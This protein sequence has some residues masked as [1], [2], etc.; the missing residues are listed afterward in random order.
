MQRQVSMETLPHEILFVI[1][2]LLSTNNLSSFM[3][4]NKNFF[5]IISKCN[6]LWQQLSFKHF[7]NDALKPKQEEHSDWYDAFK[8][9]YAHK[10][11]NH[12]LHTLFNIYSKNYNQLFFLVTDGDLRGLKSKNID[13]IDL[14]KKDN[15]NKTLIDVAFEMQHQHILDYFFQIAMKDY[16]IGKKLNTKKI[17][18]YSGNSSNS[19]NCD[20]GHTVLHFAVRC[21]QISLIPELIDK[22]ENLEV[23]TEDKFTAVQLACNNRVEILKLMLDKYPQLLD[24]LDYDGISLVSLASMNGE[25]N[26]LNFL[27]KTGAN[28]SQLNRDR[29]PIHFACQN[30]HLE[31]VKLLLAHQPNLLNATDADNQ[32][33]IIWAV[34]KKH[35]HLVRYLCEQKAQLNH[36]GGQTPYDFTALHLAAAREDWETIKVLIEFGS[37]SLK[38]SIGCTPADYTFKSHIRALIELINFIEEFSLTKNYNY[39]DFFWSNTTNTNNASLLDAALLLKSV[40]LGHVDKSRLNQYQNELNSHPLRWIYSSLMGHFPVADISNAYNKN[41]M[42]C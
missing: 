36:L 10:Y 2:F 27:L 19:E 21:N 7:G 1:S 30:G 8:Q 4:T 9:N 31:V 40:C 33:L 14:F 13:T 42:L 12:F 17:I 3:L 18:D 5:D 20:K 29:F 11:K 6:A 16:S 38:N 25:V 41:P 37:S 28:V 26:V 24:Q 35:V 32:T 39:F 34:R 22:L 23:L 15:R